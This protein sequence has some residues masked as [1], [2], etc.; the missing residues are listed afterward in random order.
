MQLRELVWL[1]VHREL[2]VGESEAAQNLKPLL[3]VP[4]GGIRQLAE[5]RVA[6]DD[7]A[8]WRESMMPAVELFRETERTNH[9]APGRACVEGSDVVLQAAVIGRPAEQTLIGA[10][11]E[12][13]RCADGGETALDDG[14]LAVG[15][16]LLSPGLPDLQEF[17]GREQSHQQRPSGALVESTG[18]ITEFDRARRAPE[19]DPE[20]VFDEAEVA[21][22]GRHRRGQFYR[23]LDDRT[24]GCP[25]IGRPR[26]PDCPTQV[27]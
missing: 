15:V 17:G 27:L 10:L 22:G 11:H 13:R 3:V 14:R 23:A 19:H 4:L 16:P 2:V 21:R 18:F 5:L 24:I 26:F 7:A 8:L 25:F 12:V 6:Q 20:D 9:L 1:A